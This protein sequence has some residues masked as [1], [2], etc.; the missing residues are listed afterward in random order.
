MRWPATIWSFGP[1]TGF[2][3]IAPTLTI[4]ACGGLMMASKNSMP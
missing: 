3:T 4:I 1:T 2:F